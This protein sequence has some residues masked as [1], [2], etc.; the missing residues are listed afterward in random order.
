[1]V[2]F[3]LWELVNYTE[4]EKMKKPYFV[5]L[6]FD[7]FYEEWH[8]A[9]SNHYSLDQVRAD[10]EYHDDGEPLLVLEIFDERDFSAV[11]H[12]ALTLLDECGKRPPRNA[13]SIFLNSGGRIA[14]KVSRV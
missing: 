10:A 9:G 14:G 8:E 6:E 11:R 2:R 4:S 12:K 7:E 3:P 5:L 13:L 1:M